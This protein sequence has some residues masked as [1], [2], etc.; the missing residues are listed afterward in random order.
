[1]KLPPGGLQ[2]YYKE[3]PAQVFFCELFTIFKN[4]YLIQDL[5]MASSETACIKAR[6]LCM[7]R[8][9]RFSQQTRWLFE[10]SYA[11]VKK[12]LNFI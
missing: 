12:M 5:Q 4:T 2:L 9:N 1:M 11:L 6:K 8:M 7:I 10:I 3:T